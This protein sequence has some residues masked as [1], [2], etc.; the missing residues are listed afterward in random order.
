M[1]NVVHQKVSFL[2]TIGSI[3]PPLKRIKLYN[4]L[5]SLGGEFATV[6]APTALI[7]KHAKIGLGTIVM[8]HAVVN[9]SAVIGDNCIINTKALIEHDAIIGNHC[10]ISTGA[11][12]NG[13]VEVGEATF[14]GSGVVSVHD[15]K[16][17]ANSFI[18]ASS[19]FIK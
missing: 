4:L 1:I 18:K 17:P 9:A 14:F 12:I 13:G 7:S 6:T 19:L 8:N 5:K 2:I 10:H 11:I 15:T 16:I 3:G